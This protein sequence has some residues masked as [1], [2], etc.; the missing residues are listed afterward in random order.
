M[1]EL[2]KILIKYW[3]YSSFRPLQED[4]IIS[5]IEGNDTLALMP[6]GGGKSIIF[7]VSALAKEG[8]CIVVT[9]LIALMNDQVLNLKKRGISAVAISS[10]LTHREIDLAFDKCIYGGVKFLYLSPERL[11]TDLFLAKLK[12][13][14][15]NLLAIDEAHCISQ[16]GYDFRPAYL[17]IA[18]VR[19]QLPNVPVL[20]LT[21]SATKEV[22]K[23]IQ[24]KL[25]FKKKNVFV[26]SFERKNLIYYVE[27]TE[28]K[29]NY[30]LRIARKNKGTGVVYVRN[31][32]GTKE[33][34]HYLQQNKI[35]ADFYHAG[36]D[37]RVRNY[38]QE[39]WINDK[40]RVI[41]S[42]NAFG[43]GIDKP[44]VRFVV[45]LDI[46]D[47][48]EAYYQEAGRGGRDEKKAYAVML[49]D[50]S[51]I[52][53][54]EKRIDTEFPDKMIIKNVYNAL[55]N[56]YNIP[57]GSG[58]NTVHEFNFKT[59]R[60]RYNFN[61]IEAFNSLKII[62]QVGLIQLSD[63]FYNPSKIMFKASKSDLYEFQVT[64][65]SF[66][67]FIKLI[68]RTYSGVF[69]DYTVINEEYLA[70][71]FKVHKS[72]ILKYLNLLNKY[73]IIDYIPETNSP[74]ITFLEERLS[75][76]NNFL[77]NENYGIRKERY[78]K[79]IESVITYVTS[80]A[81]CRSKIILE[82]FGED[83][84]TRCGTCDVCRRRNE[85]ELSKYEF[86][87]ILEILKE[88]IRNKPET[89]NYTVEN[90]DYPD[91][92]II[93]VIQWLFENNKIKYNDEMQLIW[94]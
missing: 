29:L 76:S 16:W 12:Q 42:T 41:V 57:D 51:D 62:E 71:V 31:R 35:S 84:A 36:L 32:R 8:L 48:L 27:E 20:A 5:V 4:I 37:S 86:D 78:K 2:T 9:P 80:Q 30:L 70:Q 38:K 56:F 14:N 69:N 94:L 46:P 47:S 6:T 64:N 53:N 50:N 67:S 77:T 22:A 40:V 68:L 90:I 58:K 75:K 19:E 1:T 3:G 60:E 91:H 45:H 18:E 49:Y 92:K 73:S 93:K 61:P 79:R 33:V 65:P 66:D 34:A 85:L 11:Q 10:N 83:N 87:I 82:Y 28:K 21:A 24:E 54:L 26:K 88:K 55:G 63:A 52:Q 72:V 17:R 43:M 25:N 15:V 59:F 81:K 13:M 7:Q 44:D 39:Q 74:K 23:D 89:L